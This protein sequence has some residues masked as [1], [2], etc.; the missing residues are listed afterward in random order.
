MAETGLLIVD[1][2]ITALAEASRTDEVLKL[3]NRAQQMRAYAKLAKN[4]SMQADAAVIIQRAE[5]RLG[6]MLQSAKETGQ[7][8]IGRRSKSNLPGGF[9][10]DQ[11]DKAVEIVRAAGKASTS[12]LQRKLTIGWNRALGLVE[13]MERQNIVLPPDEAGV[14]RVPGAE[15]EAPENGEDD[16]PI[17]G[18]EDERFTLAEIG[19]GRDL[20]ARAQKKARLGE[21]DFEATL[22]ALRER[23]VAGGAKVVQAEGHNGA[24]M[25]GRSEPSGSLDYFPTP[26]W[27]T[28]TL[29]LDVLAPLGISLFE[30]LLEDPCCGEGHI[31]GVLEEYSYDVIGSDI[32]DYSRDGVSPPGW[33]A[34]YDYLSG[35]PDCG[36]PPDWVITNPPFGKLTLQV[37]LK[38]LREARVGVAMFVRSQWAVEGIESYDKLF[39]DNPPTIEAYFTERVP[40]V[41]GRWDPEASTMTAYCWL[42]WIKGKAPR[43]LFRIPPGRRLARSRPDDAARFTAHPV[44]SLFSTIPAQDSSGTLEGKSK[45]APLASVEALANDG[46]REVERADEVVTGGESAATLNSVQPDEPVDPAGATPLSSPRQAPVAA[47]GPEDEPPAGEAAPSS[48]ANFPAPRS[49]READRS[50][51]PL[52]SDEQNAII[53]AGYA[54]SPRTS[55]AAL[56]AATGLGRS[57]VFERA[58]DLGLTNKAHQRAAVAEANK[59]RAGV[60]RAEQ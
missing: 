44:R 48:P 33:V 54:R 47:E 60:K 56:M 23:I 8:G 7:L 41:K 24:T 32:H 46:E 43:P 52:T 29:I 55:T 30:L 39:R 4:R 38:A 35:P 57:A 1:T 34:T 9:A 14:R 58:K 37:I 45:A 17:P 53:R 13:E 10:D 25:A 26:P 51:A 59:R 22:V 31:S 11:W 50:G 27:A 2:A 16:Q 3:R 21:D 18:G 12:L 49:G 6:Q 15:A 20:A 40:L 5:R 36:D 19:V 28:R 42:V